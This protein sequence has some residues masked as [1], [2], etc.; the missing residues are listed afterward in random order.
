MYVFSRFA[1][2]STVEGG[3][4]FNNRVRIIQVSGY[5]LS[6]VSEEFVD[7]GALLA[8]P[9]TEYSYFGIYPVL[10]GVIVTILIYLVIKALGGGIEVN[11]QLFLKG[12]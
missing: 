2:S 5:C 3:G 1:F 8:V 6:R 12:L 9:S 10:L 11:E 4:V 7:Q